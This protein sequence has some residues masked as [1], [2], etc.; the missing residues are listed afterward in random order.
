MQPTMLENARFLCRSGTDTAPGIMRPS[1]V[2]MWLVLA[3]FLAA[4][5][6]TS[7]AVAENL[8]LREISRYL[9]ELSL[10]E[11]RFTQVSDDGY[12]TTGRLFISRPGKMRMDYDPPEQ[13]SVIVSHGAVHI[14]D[15]K[16]NQP[17]EIYPLART[18]LAPVLARH[19]DLENSATVVNRSYDGETTIVTL[20][21]PK[22]PERGQMDLYFTDS[23]LTLRKWVLTDES[24]MRTEMILGPITRDRPQP[25][26][27]YHVPR[28]E[29]N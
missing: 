10:A 19:V 21:P 27:L 7:P 23:P 29:R 16:S 2:R 13:S 4:G 24:G 20:Q 22:Q 18:P 11:S 8:T 12:R 1:R 15:R 9:G 25:N 5:P 17:P 26:G 3:A 6:T 28:P 14:I